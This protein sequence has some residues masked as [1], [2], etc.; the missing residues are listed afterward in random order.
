MLAGHYAPTKTFPFRMSQFTRILHFK[1][2]EKDSTPGARPESLHLVAIISLISISI[3]SRGC[4]SWQVN[5]IQSGPTQIR[6]ET[7]TCLCSIQV[8]T[9]G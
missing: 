5:Q 9:S 1:Q 3:E 6:S 8:G 4:S 7:Q 2:I